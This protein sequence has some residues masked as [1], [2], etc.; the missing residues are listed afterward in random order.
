MAS[1]PVTTKKAPLSFKSI[2]PSSVTATVDVVREERL[3][4]GTLPLLVR[5]VAPQVD[6]AA[7]AERHHA[8]VEAK[9]VRH[10]A[11]LFR[12]FDIATPEKL[13]RFASTSKT[14]LFAEN[15]EHPHISG[16][17][18]KPVFF[19]PTEKLLWHNENTFNAAWPRRV[20]FACAKPSTSGGETPLVDSRAV[21]RE[22]PSALRARFVKHGVMYVRNYRQGIGLA[23]Q[24]VFGTDSRS[25]VEAACTAEGMTCEWIGRDSLRTR[26][27]RAAA[28]PHPLTGEMCWFNQAQHWHISCVDPKTGAALRD[29]YAEAELPRNC[30]YG[31]GSPISDETMASILAVYA[32]LEV[33]FPWRAGDVV[34][35]DN[36]LTAHA[37]NS[38]VGE[39]RLL[40]ALGDMCKVD[41]YGVVTA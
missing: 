23:W 18:Y 11:I 15:G 32:R 24:D 37:R 7:W 41:R 19:P 38:F 27:V 10:G 12:N 35:I 13:E 16:R 25:D 26:A 22:L 14:A 34:L 31:D 30:Y 8:E 4:V 5:A 1:T 29:L 40:V 20:W 2:K 36:I 28:G 33:V 39:R 17:V 9:L 3:G 6:L 21:Y